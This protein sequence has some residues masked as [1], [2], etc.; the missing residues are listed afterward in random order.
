MQ[1]EGIVNVQEIK[2]ETTISVMTH[3][4]GAITLVHSGIELGDLTLYLTTKNPD[5][6]IISIFIRKMV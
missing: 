1:D 5:G 2:I 3:A 4:N 6:R